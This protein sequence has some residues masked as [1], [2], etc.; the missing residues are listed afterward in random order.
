MSR[1]SGDGGDAVHCARDIS[2]LS[3]GGVRGGIAQQVKSGKKIYFAKISRRCEI[4]TAS[5]NDLPI[6]G[7]AKRI[8]GPIT[9]NA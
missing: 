4:P 6:P 1:R 8:P 9:T 3:E 7:F 5:N 2:S